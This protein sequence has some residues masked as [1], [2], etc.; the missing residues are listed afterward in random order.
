[1]CSRYNVPF[2]DLQK[3]NYH[4]YDA[5]GMKIKLCDKA[6]AIDYMINMP[7]LKGH[8]KTAISL[9]MAAV[10]VVELLLLSLVLH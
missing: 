7:V 9:I 4:E 8:C 10:G 5:T 2:E 1:M 3:N 6:H